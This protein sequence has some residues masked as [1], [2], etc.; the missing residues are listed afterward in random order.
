MTDSNVFE[1]LLSICFRYVFFDGQTL[2]FA[3]AE[4]LDIVEELEALQLQR[5]KDDLQPS[6]CPLFLPLFFS[7]VLDIDL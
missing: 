2:G 1:S 3:A 5:M 4:L 6:S 7:K